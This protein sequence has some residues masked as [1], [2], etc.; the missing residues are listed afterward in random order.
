MREN[1]YLKLLRR[2]GAL[3]F[4]ATA[5]VG[6]LQISMFGLGAVLLVS[7]HKG[8][9]GLAG[10]VAAADATG[11]AA[12]SPL[13][14]RL[15]DRRGQG[16]VLRPVMAVFG[17]ATSGLIVGVIEGAP[18]WT[19]LLASTIAGAATPQLGSMV[20]SRWSALL[21][22]SPLLHTAFSLES[23]ADEVI[24]VVGP[25][26]VTI[27]ATQ[28]SPSAGL[29]VGGA[30]CVVGTLAFADQRRSEPPLQIGQRPPAEESR[31]W[32]RRE[33][34]RGLVK[35][36]PVFVAF[37][38]MLAA[39]D[40]STVAFATGRGHRSLAGVLLGGYAL[41][42]ALGGLWYGARDWRSS[43][44]RRFGV[45]IWLAALGSASFWAMPGLAALGAAMFISGLVLSPMLITGFSLIEQ[46]ALPGR[47]TEAMAWVTS[48]ISL[49]TAVGAAVAGQVIDA[50]GPRWGYGLAA[51]LG[52]AAV[53]AKPKL[54]APG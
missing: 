9:Y 28:V 51:L 40:V 20:R 34:A 22:K 32:D 29:V 7:A 2:P 47:L 48:A 15:A 21:G 30:T 8:H 26:L 42:S 10:G 16:V 31:A 17:A 54:G 35:L 5:F 12:V 41:G 1:P 39:I 6:R 19:L 38:A 25:V 49:G 53:L 14:A 33:P 27:L 3:H 18:A 24:F 50:A 46:Q 52:A 36:V 11:Y 45:T 44:Q 43:T 4:S 23:V 37:G 13:V